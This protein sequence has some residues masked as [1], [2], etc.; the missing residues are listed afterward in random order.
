MWGAGWKFYRAVFLLRQR[1]RIIE[2]QLF[3]PGTS[4]VGLR[5]RLVA[6]DGNLERYLKLQFRRRGKTRQHLRVEVHPLLR[7]DGP[8]P[9]EHALARFYDGLVVPVV[10]SRLVGRDPDFG[11]S[12]PITRCGTNA[13][14][15]PGRAGC[16]HPLGG[17][18]PGTDG[19]SGSGGS[20]GLAVLVER[21]AGE[22]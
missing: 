1:R 14:Q 22:R 17:D 12:F 16:V 6:V 11:D 18:T 13:M 5:L 10:W 20:E 8:T 3:E 4:L 19:P 9:P 2:A 21:R 7:R 15:A